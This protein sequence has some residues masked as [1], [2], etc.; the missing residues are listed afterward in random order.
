VSTATPRGLLKV[1]VAP[2]LA[3]PVALVELPAT[4]D[5]TPPGVIMRMRWLFTSA[6][7]KLPNESS[8]TL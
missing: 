1:E 7:N 3:E 5:T 4:V 8:A 2:L 6:T